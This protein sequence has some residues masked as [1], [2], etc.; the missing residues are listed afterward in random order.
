M[1]LKVFGVAL[2]EN[3]ITTILS[4][5]VEDQTEAGWPVPDN[6]PTPPHTSQTSPDWTERRY[7]CKLDGV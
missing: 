4:N 5:I 3:A 6:P 1:P 7:S 2:S